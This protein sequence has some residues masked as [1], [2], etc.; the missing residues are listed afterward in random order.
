MK[1]LR[2]SE[3]QIAYASR[4]AGGNAPV[5]DGCRQFGVSEATFY[6]W[7]KKY[8]KLGE[9]ELREVHQLQD[10]SRRLKRPVS[11]LKLDKHILSEVIRKKV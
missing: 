10:Q 11:D 5:R 7:K 4:Q 9:S 8:G 6:L 1:K 2:Y 3:E